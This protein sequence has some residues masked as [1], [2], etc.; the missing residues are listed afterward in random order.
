MNWNQLKEKAK[1][2]GYNLRGSKSRHTENLSKGKMV[3]Y[4]DGK[5][6]YDERIDAFYY[7]YYDAEEYGD[8][9]I[10]ETDRTPDQMWQIMEAL[11]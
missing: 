11:K 7:D 9:H 10:I 8:V 6:V 4:E 2:L 5:F 3:F 1:E